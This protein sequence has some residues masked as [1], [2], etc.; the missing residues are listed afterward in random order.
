[1]LNRA[2]WLDEGMLRG[3][4]VDV[5]VFDFS[6][7]L[8]SDQLAPLGFLL[9]ERL[10]A[11]L[12]SSRNYVH[13][14]LPLPAGVAAL[15]LFPRMAPRLLSRRAALV[16]LVLIA[17]SDDLVY[18]SSEFKPYSLD[19]FFGVAITLAAVSALGREPP[20][21]T[22]MWLAVLAVTAPWFSFSSVFTIAGC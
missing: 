1:L 9:V 2:M 21:R 17:L 6:E 7:P 22:V 15:E 14:F 10:L 3:N 4:V 18:Y 5:P 16:A 8:K 19:L 13:R 20:M 11:S 12:V